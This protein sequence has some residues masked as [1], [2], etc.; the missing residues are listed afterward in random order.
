MELEDDSL[1]PAQKRQRMLDDI[2][3]AND[4]VTEEEDTAEPMTYEELVDVQ[5][6][7]CFACEYINQDAMRDN[8]NYLAMMRL[9]TQNAGSIC[10]DAIF[11]QIKRFFDEVIKPD[12]DEVYRDK[13]IDWSLKCIREHFL[14]HTSMPTDEILTQIR[15]KRALRTKLANNLVEKLADGRLRFNNH[16]I[17]HMLA[18]DKEILVLLKSRKDI[19]SMCG[20]NEVLDY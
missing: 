8:D 10:S 15:I 16:N 5:Y 4:E 19:A 17:K 3:L 12:L 9:Y 20:Y 7:S 6:T 1:S 14:L 13:K 2:V 11:V 18:L